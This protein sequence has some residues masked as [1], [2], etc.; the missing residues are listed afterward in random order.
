MYDEDLMDQYE[1]LMSKMDNMKE[2]IVHL[3]QKSDYSYRDLFKKWLGLNIQFIAVQTQL[4]SEGVDLLELYR[5]R[6]RQSEDL[7][8]LALWYKVLLEESDIKKNECFAIKD[9]IDYEEYDT[10]Q[11]ERKRKNYEKA[12]SEYIDL[13]D[14]LFFVCDKLEFFDYDFK[15]EC[16]R[17]Y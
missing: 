14:E 12:M 8:I 5:Q 7:K 4:K 9:N 3:Y 17:D 15:N 16:F 6:I 13:Q 1:T 11:G 2:I 10:P